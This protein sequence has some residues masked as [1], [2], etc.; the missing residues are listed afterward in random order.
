MK[1]IQ[2]NWSDFISLI[3]Y[4]IS[5]NK[6]QI[7]DVNVISSGSAQWLLKMLVLDT[8]DK[9]DLFVIACKNTTVYQVVKMIWNPKA[10]KNSIWAWNRGM[11]MGSISMVYQPIVF[12]PLRLA[13]KSHIEYVGRKRETQ[14]D[15]KM[16]H[17]PTLHHTYLDGVNGRSR[18]SMA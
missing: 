8:L 6:R 13:L 4:I 16:K 7:W 15:I 1:D 17:W 2:G 3:I 12:V 11:H 10:W 9:W 5:L 14:G 18:R